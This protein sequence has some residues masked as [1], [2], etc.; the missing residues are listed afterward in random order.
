MQKH[1]DSNSTKPW[2]HSPGS[3]EN[4]HLLIVTIFSMSNLYPTIICT[5]DLRFELFDVLCARNIHK[6]VVDHLVCFILTSSHWYIDQVHCVENYLQS[7]AV[8]YKQNLHVVSR[9]CHKNWHLD[10]IKIFSL[11]VI[12]SCWLIIDDFPTTFSCMGSSAFIIL[13]F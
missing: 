11:Y 4:M 12:I 8:W 1:S 5:G 13:P 2:S 10:K 9:L 7:E 3:N 6:L